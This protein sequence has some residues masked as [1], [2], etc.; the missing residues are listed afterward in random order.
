MSWAACY[1]HLQHWQ[2]SRLFQKP[3]ASLLPR[4][5][6]D[7]SISISKNKAN[8]GINSVPSPNPEKKVRIDAENAVMPIINKSIYFF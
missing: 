2:H 4:L 3:Q 7:P 5:G 6:E 8:T 1:H